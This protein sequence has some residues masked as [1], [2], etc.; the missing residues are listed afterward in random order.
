MKEQDENMLKAVCD[1]LESR[2]FGAY[3]CKTKEEALKQALALIP[4][5][6]TI[7]FGGSKT[8]EE[9]G[10]MDA[11]R[12]GS[13]HLLDRDAAKSQAER[14]QIMKQSL[15]SDVFLT[16]TNAVTKT[17]ELVNIDGNGNRVAAMTYGPDQVIVVC[18]KNKIVEDVMAGAGRARNVAAPRNA[19]RFQ[20][21]SIPCHEDG[22]C[23]DCNSPDSICTYI[24]RTR[25]CNPKG[26]IQ[27]ILVDEELGF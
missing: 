9:I 2:G 21:L 5:D 13:Y 11:V 18:G 8:L 25:R 10:L 24:V 27:V 19:Q 17:G 14:V 7:G 22:V 6:V 3:Y 1:K 20:N 12:K 16:G 15:T 26:R 23:H 4:K